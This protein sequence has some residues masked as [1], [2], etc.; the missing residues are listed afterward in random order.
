MKASA[1][2]SNDEFFGMDKKRGKVFKSATKIWE[3]RINGNI[4]RNT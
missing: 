4:E 3:K 2:A 1:F